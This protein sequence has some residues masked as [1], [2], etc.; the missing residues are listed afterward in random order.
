MSNVDT[1]VGRQLDLEVRGREVAR[2]SGEGTRGAWL[3]RARTGV[4]RRA[5]VGL[6]GWLDSWV[7]EME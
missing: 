3:G 1:L 6:V 4:H 5:L 2:G 7:Q